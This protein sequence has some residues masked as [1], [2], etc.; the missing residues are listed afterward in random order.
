MLVEQDAAAPSRSNTATSARE[1]RIGVTGVMVEAFNIIQ[2]RISRA[3][4]AG[5]PPDMTLQPKLGHVGLTDFHRAVQAKPDEAV[6]F[7]WITWPDKATRD[8]AWSKS[9]EDDRMKNMQMPFD[10]KRM[11]YGGFAPIYEG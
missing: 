7:S 6:V 8:Q 3:R 11:I 4:L 10:G 9:M 2:D 1:S 5:D